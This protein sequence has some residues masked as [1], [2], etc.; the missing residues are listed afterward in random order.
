M[1]MQPSKSVSSER[2]RA[3]LARGCTSWAIDT[4]SLGRSTT[5][6]KPAAAQQAPRAAEGARAGG[7][8]LP[9]VEAHAPAS[10]GAPLTIISFTTETSTVMPRSLKDPVWELPHCLIQILD[11]HLLVAALCPQ[12][13]R[14]GPSHRDELLG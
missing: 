1:A 12:E 7:A 13:R 11:A 10:I 8:E 2:T 6:G 5:A 14:D 3:P 9:P 4:R